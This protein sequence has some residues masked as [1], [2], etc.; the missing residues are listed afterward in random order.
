MLTDIKQKDSKTCK[1]FAGQF[2]TQENSA[3][4][5]RMV[6]TQLFQKQSRSTNLSKLFGRERQCK[7][8]GGTTH[9]KTQKSE[10]NLT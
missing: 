4:A 6:M 10:A 1:P 5:S 2:A 3:L 8:G 7:G 9:T